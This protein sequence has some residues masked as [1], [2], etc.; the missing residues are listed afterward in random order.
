MYKMNLKRNLFFSILIVFLTSFVS[1]SQEKEARVLIETDLGNIV[2]KLYNETPLHRDNFLKLVD[3]KFYDGT[4]FH[5][6]IYSF[7]IQGGDPQSK[8]AEPGQMLGNGGTGYTIPAEFNPNLFH[9]KGALCAARQGDNVN[10]KK[11]SS[12]CQFYI[13]QGKQY[14]EDNLKQFENRKDREQKNMIFR[15]CTS[16]PEYQEF[17]NSWNNAQQNKDQGKLDSLIN[18]ITPEIDSLFEKS[19]DKFRFTPEQIEAYSTVGGTPHLDGGYTVFGEV[20][21]GLD[22]IDKIAQLTTDNRDRPN[23]DITIKMK[24]LK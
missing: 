20:V 19:E 1:I 10:P 12:G 13:V 8:S 22:V 11:E 7:M 4:L 9:K 17:A 3:D 24:I 6:V 2:V 15:E 18:V 21:D 5:R 16:K 23:R 14:T